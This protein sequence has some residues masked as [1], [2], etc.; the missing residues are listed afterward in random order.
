[1][2]DEAVHVMRK[3]HSSKASM[4]LWFLEKYVNGATIQWNRIQE[5]RRALPGPGPGVDGT[6]MQALFL[7]I[8]FYFVCYDKAQNLLEH[9]AALDGDLELNNLWQ[10]IGPQFRPFNDA[11]NHLEHIEE[12]IARGVSDLGNLEKET[13]TFDGERFDVSA[14]GLRILTDAYEQVVHIL[15]SR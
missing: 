15:R 5:T 2:Y 6:L 12:R 10:T 7:D 3:A 1:M 4:T 11:R 9:F 8:H 13:Y 14:S